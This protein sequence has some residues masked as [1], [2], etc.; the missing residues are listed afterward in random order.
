MAKKSTDLAIVFADIN[1]STRL[2]ELLGDAAAR[3][4]VAACL[5]ML[6]A[7]TTRYDGTVIKTIG[8][9]IMCTFP[10]AEAAASSAREMQ[11][12]PLAAPAKCRNQWMTM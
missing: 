1:G 12:L 10:N 8:D 9:E 6:S 11:K 2:Y 5:D 7:V 4:K 3:A